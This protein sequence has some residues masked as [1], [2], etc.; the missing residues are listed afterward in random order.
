MNTKKIKQVREVYIKRYAFKSDLEKEN[1]DE[2]IK[3]S[4]NINLIKVSPREIYN[5]HHEIN[6]Y[7]ENFL[8]TDKNLVYTFQTWTF[9]HELENN[10]ENID[11]AIGIN[12]FTDNRKLLKNQC[13]LEKFL[14]SKGFMKI[15]WTKCLSY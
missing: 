2:I 14:L 10:E 5:D 12:K 6:D 15:D 13:N 4:F 3:K 1:V 7:L 11:Y 8:G 9:S